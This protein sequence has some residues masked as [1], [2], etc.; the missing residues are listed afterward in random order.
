MRSS[1][2]LIT[3]ILC[4]LLAVGL[5]F[6]AYPWATYFGNFTYGFVITVS[7][8]VIVGLIVGIIASASTFFLSLFRSM[9]PIGQALMTGTSMLVSLCALA[10][11]LGPFGMEIP[12]TRARGIF[13]D[14]WNFITFTSEVS[15]PAAVLAGLITWLMVRREQR[16]LRAITR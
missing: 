15:A 2:V 4:V 8:Y 16:V 3:G 5:E 12:G 13:F 11:I 14:E 10:L 6:W 9:P 1:R 7:S